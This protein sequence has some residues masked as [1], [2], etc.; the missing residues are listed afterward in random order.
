MNQAKFVTLNG[1]Q[2]RKG[3]IVHQH[4]GRFLCLTNAQASNGHIDNAA[5]WPKAGVGPTCCGVT[6]SVCI[7][8]EQSG[9]F[10]PGSDWNLQGNHRASFTVEVDS[11]P[12]E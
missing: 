2:L 3:M 1:Q 6:K 9:Y 7:E 8:G 5:Y 11:I 10:K 12:K 4:G